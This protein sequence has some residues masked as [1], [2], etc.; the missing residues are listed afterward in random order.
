LG[1]SLSLDVEDSSVINGDAAD[2]RQGQAA[3]VM[4]HGECDWRLVKP[5]SGNP[6]SVEISV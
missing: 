2:G 3:H 5:R 1:F 6:V 4:G